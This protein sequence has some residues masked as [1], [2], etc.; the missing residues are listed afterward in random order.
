MR[1]E[2]A[3]VDVRA[4]GQFRSGE[5]LGILFVSNLMKRA[6]ARCPHLRLE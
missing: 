2:R 4:I 3:Y 6:L 5:C 1:V